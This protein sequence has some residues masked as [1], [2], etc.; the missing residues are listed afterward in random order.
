[1][2]N[3]FTNSVYRI[4]CISF[5]T[6]GCGHVFFGLEC[7]DQC[8]YPNYGVQCQSLS[9]CESQLCNHISGC[10]FSTGK[11]VYNVTIETYFMCYTFI[12]IDN[13][14]EFRVDD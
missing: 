7:R 13:D 2:I 11:S 8:R 12:F 14:D 5:R 10:N 3:L 9:A 4:F 6:L 1:M